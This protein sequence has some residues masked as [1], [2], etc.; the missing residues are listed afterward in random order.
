L[1]A[2][3]AC[4]ALTQFD[5]LT[6]NEGAQRLKCINFVNNE[7]KLNGVFVQTFHDFFES[8]SKTNDRLH[9]ACLSLHIVDSTPSEIIITDNETVMTTSGGISVEV[10]TGDLVQEKADVIV[11]SVRNRLEL[12][13]G[14][15]KA[16]ADNAGDELRRARQE[17]VGL[18]DAYADADVVHVTAGRLRPEIRWVLLVVGPPR[19]RYRGREQ[20][21]YR[22][23]VDSF[24]NCLIYANGVLR[25]SSISLPAIS[26]GKR[27]VRQT[28]F[29]IAVKL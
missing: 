13:A 9:Q 21:Y 25:T 24:Y 22:T 11:C 28:N 2:D 1:V 26:A 5:A 29:V 16:V 14:A 23:L 19:E 27:D 12:A 20:D 6:Q 10:S 3:A 7:T 4:M 8:S 15:A 18:V 17:Y